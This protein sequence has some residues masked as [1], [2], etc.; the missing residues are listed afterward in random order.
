MRRAM[1]GMVW[2]RRQRSKFNDVVTF[3]VLVRYNSK[4]QNCT[5]I[6]VNIR[7]GGMRTFFE[8]RMLEITHL[9]RNGNGSSR[10]TIYNQLRRRI[11]CLEKL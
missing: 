6:R 7:K 5:K 2:Q 9:I 10:F 4:V 11:K 1:N 3:M 8:N